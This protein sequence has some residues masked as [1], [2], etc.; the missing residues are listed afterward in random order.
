MRRR[1]ARPRLRRRRRARSRAR[2]AERPLRV[3][4]LACTNSA[5]AAPGRPARRRTERPRPERSPDLHLLKPKV[6]SRLAT[7]TSQHARI[8]QAPASAGPLTA[9]TTGA[10]HRRS[11]SEHRSTVP[12]LVGFA[13]RP[14]RGS[15]SHLAE[16][17]PA[18]TPGPPRRAVP[19][20]HQHVAVALYSGKALLQ[21]RSQR[22]LRA[23]RRRSAAV[24]DHAAPARATAHAATPP[25]RSSTSPRATVSPSATCTARHASGARRDERHL[26]LHRLDDDEACPRL[27]LV[28]G[29]DEDADHRPRHRRAHLVLD[30]ATRVRVIGLVEIG[31]RRN[32]RRRQVHAEGRPPRRRR[33]RVEARASA[34]GN[35]AQKVGRRLARAERR[36]RDEPAQER[37]VRDDPPTSVSVERLTERSD[38][39]LAGRPVA[40]SA[41][42]SSGRTASRSC[43]PASTPGV[44][45]HTARKPQPL[46]PARLGQERPRIL[47]VEPHLDRM[48][49]REAGRRDR[50]P[51]GDPDLV[52]DEIAVRS[53]ARSRDARPGSARSA[54]GRRTRRPATRN[55][56]V[57]ALRVADRAREPR[58]GAESAAHRAS[59]IAGDGDSSST[60]WWRRWIE[61][62][63]LAEREHVPVRV[64]EQ[65][66]LDVRAPAPRSA[67][68][69]PSR[70][71]TPPSPPA[72]QPPS[73]GSSSGA[74][75]TRIPRPPPPPRPSPAAGSRSRRRRPSRARRHAGRRGDP[76]RFDLVA[77]GPQRRRRRPDPD[78]PGCL[79]R[80]GQLG[81]L[82]EEAVARM[83]R[84]RA[85]VSRAARTYSAGIE[86]ARDRDRLAGRRA[87]GARRHRPEPPRA[88][89]AIPSS[90]Q[91]RKT[92]TAI[93]PRF[94]TSSL[95][96]PRRR[97]HMR[98]MPK[99]VSGIGASSA[100]EIPSASTCRV[101]S[102]SMIPSSQSRAVE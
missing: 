16:A 68:R 25:G 63:A 83:N 13:P 76:L 58:R 28:A 48:A 17:A 100:A 19:G 37:Q 84:V 92:R 71:R 59:S 67:R 85:R 21:R 60:F 99:R 18:G 89:V 81:A 24:S 88:T 23:A 56:A 3:E 72:P 5:R 75:T 101:S 11:A 95:R 64:G 53:R 4:P 8:P 34:A 45:A 93:S 29:G 9:A 32:R 90:R 102:G 7:T 78:E 50:V 30:L 79:D 96:T 55:S 40:R 31:R 54:R 82:R 43:R 74:R 77:A 87:C 10:G 98:K 57:P 47:G 14:A 33:Q 51:L 69:R 97:A 26:H 49:S 1:L 52:G 65:L 22:D 39:L 94:A 27:D 20:R 2:V 46:D 70:R 35:A 91:V 41:S 36:M 6:A 66:H 80:L 86:V 73:A 62:S 38:R 15:R 12:C 42:R 44:D 61:H